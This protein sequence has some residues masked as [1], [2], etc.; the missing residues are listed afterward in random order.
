[1]RNKGAVTSGLFALLVAAPVSPALAE[2]EAPSWVLFE[3]VHVFDG[4]SAQLQR[5]MHVLVEGNKIKSVSSAKIDAPGANV[6]TGGGRTL[7]PGMM[8]LHSHLNMNAATAPN[9]QNDMNWEEIAVR[10]ARMAKDWLMDGFTTIRDMGGMGT[11]LQKSIDQGIVV[12]PRIYPAGGWIGPTGGH[13]D[14]RN[15]TTPNAGIDGV[16]HAQTERL[17]M[18]FNADGVDAIKRAARQNFMQLNTQLKIM[19]SGGVTSVWDPWQLDG[20]TAEE[21][22]AAVEVAEGYGSYVGAHAYSKKSIMRCL[23]NGVKTIEHGFMFDGEVNE[24]MKKKGAFLVTQMTSMSPLLAKIDALQNPRVAYKLN[25]AQ[26]AFGSYVENVKKYKP[27][28][29]FMIDCVGGPDAC[30][31]QRAY[32][33]W[34]HADFFGNHHMLVAATGTAGEIVALTGKVV[35]PYPEAKLGVIEEGAYADILLVD[36]NPFEDIGAIGGIDKWFD[37]PPRDGVETIRIIMKD[38]VIY[39]NTLP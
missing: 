24:L 38:G 19:P 27:R 10:S 25:T 5:G 35:N 11:G 3:N 2:N 26:A 18:A 36:G 37:A 32:E 21:I 20:Y 30:S 33:K 16:I 1:M 8:D 23:E 39:K 7:M 12:G 14:F 31:Q 6:I 17:G 28:F 22:R 13:S 4:H 9:I 29:G 34:L 15:F